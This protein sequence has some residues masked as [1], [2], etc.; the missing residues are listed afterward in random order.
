MCTIKYMDS[1]CKFTVDRYDRYLSTS[2]FFIGY[3]KIRD[4]AVLVWRVFDDI[5]T[6][7]MIPLEN[8][9]PIP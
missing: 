5:V 1:I 7:F 8:G 6:Y 4:R 3:N 2:S 9:I